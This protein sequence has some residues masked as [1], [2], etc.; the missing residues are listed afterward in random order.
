MTNTY[1]NNINNIIMLT[2][3][4]HL[5]AQKCVPISQFFNNS[6]KVTYMGI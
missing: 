3:R 6:L 1:N 2:K 4:R 5:K